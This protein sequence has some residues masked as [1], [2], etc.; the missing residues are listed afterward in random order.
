MT[1]YIWHGFQVLA[2]HAESTGAVITD[3]VYSDSRMIAKVNSG[4]T[5]YFLSDRLSV[6]VVLN[7]SGTVLGR[8]SHL[9]FGESFGESGTQDKRHFTSYE[10]D[11]EAGTDYAVN[12]QYSQSAGRFT[13]SDPN[14]ESYDF[15]N[16]QSLNRYAY[17]EGVVDI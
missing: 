7:A 14:S 16:S 10:R 4:A 17:S 15:N 3:Y 13:R 2:E 6:R 12:R 9:P 5:T 8:Q 1:H 11:V